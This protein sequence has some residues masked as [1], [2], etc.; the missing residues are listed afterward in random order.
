MD[1]R[2]P[3]RRLGSSV[4]TAFDGITRVR[5][6]SLLVI[7]ANLLGAAT[8]RMLSGSLRAA[9]GGLYGEMLGMSIALVGAGTLGALLL[10]GVLG[11]CFL[12]HYQR[13]SRDRFVGEE[14][15]PA[16]ADVAL[17]AGLLVS[18]GLLVWVGLA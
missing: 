15:L 17:I 12:S 14:F 16:W 8:V 2:W 7:G 4:T 13:R 1:H 3:L 6:L 5:L 18:A 9:G 10:S 11:S